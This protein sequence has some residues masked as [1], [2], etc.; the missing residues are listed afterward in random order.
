MRKDEDA[1]K[2]PHEAPAD[3]ELPEEEA[4]DVK[5]GFPSGPPQFPSGPPT[6]PSKFPQGP[7][8]NPSKFPQG[9]PT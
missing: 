4:A 1:K 5:G 6:S 3:L 2:S 8:Q 7:P 9:P